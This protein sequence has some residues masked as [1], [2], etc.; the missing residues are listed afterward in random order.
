VKGSLI[1]K[2]TFVQKQTV[3]F[4]MVQRNDTKISQTRTTIGQQLKFADRKTIAYTAPS[5]VITQFPAWLS[6]GFLS[7]YGEIMYEHAPQSH[8]LV[9]CP[10]SSSS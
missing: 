1:T 7:D 9:V 10:N 2:N 5:T 8:H 4:K 3:V 6:C